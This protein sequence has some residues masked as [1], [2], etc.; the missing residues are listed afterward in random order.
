MSGADH[1]QPWMKKQPCRSSLTLFTFWIS[2]V[3]G[4][5]SASD[6]DGN[7]T[8]F[9]SGVVLEQQARKPFCNKV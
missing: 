6:A 9:V 1:F 5:G 4:L 2:T 7:W 8:V 3:H